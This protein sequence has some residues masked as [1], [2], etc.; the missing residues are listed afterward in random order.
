MCETITICL[1]IPLFIDVCFPCR[2]II[3]N[4][5]MNIQVNVHGAHG[6]TLLLD[7]YLGEELRAHREYRNTSFYC[8]PQITVFFLL[9][10]WAKQVY[11]C[12]FSSSICLFT[13]LC[14]ILVIVAIFQTFHY[15]VCYG[16]LWSVITTCWMLK[17]LAFF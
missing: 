11:W 16:D 6:Y 15:S 4:A 8:P 7:R 10:A 1:F 9:K 5:T 2:D 17:W 3:N 12:H 14:Y 13:F